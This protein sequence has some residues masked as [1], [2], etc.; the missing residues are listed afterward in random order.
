MPKPYRQGQLDGLCGV[1]AMVNA[2]DVLC[3]PISKR[4][5]KSLFLEILAFL[6]SRGP[7]AEQCTYGIVVQDMA[8]ILKHVICKQYPIQRS[9]PFHGRPTVDKQHYLQTLDDFLQ[10][11]QTVV[12]TCI[13]GYLNHWTLIERITDKAL[14][15]YDSYGIRFLLQRS[16][17]MLHD[18]DEKLHRLMPTHTY[19]LKRKS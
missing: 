5:A 15:C 11:P 14:H 8:A 18:E 7:I 12:L 19:L 3:G 17:S 2:V 1:Y 4:H 6:E 9:K 10:Q 13:E 16:C